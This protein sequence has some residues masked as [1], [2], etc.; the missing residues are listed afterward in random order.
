MCLELGVRG[1]TVVGQR[2]I[3]PRSGGGRANTMYSARFP[4]N[5]SIIS[6]GQAFHFRVAL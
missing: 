5:I 1:D 2:L 3:S 4:V 6:L